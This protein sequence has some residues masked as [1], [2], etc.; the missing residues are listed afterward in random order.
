VRS[1]RSAELSGPRL[2][3]TATALA[4]VAARARAV[5]GVMA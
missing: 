5:A 4:S 3:R 1:T 2:N